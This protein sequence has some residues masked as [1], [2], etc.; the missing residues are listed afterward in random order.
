MAWD[1]WFVNYFTFIYRHNIKAVSF[2]NEDWAT[3]NI[4][5]ISEW[6]DSRLQNNLKIAS[7][8]FKETDK[9]RYLKQSDMLFEAL[10]FE[11]SGK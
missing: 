5:G 2:I 3:V 8:W 9:V 11:A 6:K 1:Q 4:E 10:G 7:A